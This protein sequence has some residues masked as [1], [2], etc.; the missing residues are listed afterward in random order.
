MSYAI[1]NIVVGAEM[2]DSLRSFIDEI[3]HEYKDLGW[4]SFY[5][6]GGENPV[7]C[8]EVIGEFDETENLSANELIAKL[9]PTPEQWQQGQ[10]TMNEARKKVIEF[11]NT[12]P[13]PPHP[14]DDDSLDPEEI[15]RLVEDLP[16]QAECLI[17]WSSS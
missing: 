4:Q 9:Q 5:S 2:P 8:G 1:A 15:K 16:I 12:Y 14:D 10:A 17:I 3:N 7:Y 6:G 13:T 11:L